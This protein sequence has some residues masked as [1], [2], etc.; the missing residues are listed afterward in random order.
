MACEGLRLAR[1]DSQVAGSAH[2]GEIGLRSPGRVRT[3]VSVGQGAPLVGR[4]RQ[5]IARE[6][7]RPPRVRRPP[8]SLNVHLGEVTTSVDCFAVTVQVP[9][10]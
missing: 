2:A 6:P 8:H 1:F 3:V 4:E 5:P 7:D 10:G 9:E